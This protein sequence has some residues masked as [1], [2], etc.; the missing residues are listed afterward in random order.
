[1][2][3]NLIWL[4]KK[5]LLSLFILVVLALLVI[6]GYLYSQ[7]W[8]THNFQ[9]LLLG[10]PSY[11]KP[12]AFEL[13]E[14]KV[15]FNIK[16]TCTYG[17][18]IKFAA[19][20]E[21]GRQM[22]KDALGNTYPKGFTMPAVMDIHLLDKDNRTIAARHNFG[23]SRSPAGTYGSKFVNFYTRVGAFL[24][25]GTYT[26]VINIKEIQK[27]LS[28]FDSSIVMSSDSHGN[29]GIRSWHV[30]NGLIN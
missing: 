9:S 15:K 12:F 24:D 27:D 21:Y 13:G 26:V 4:V 6:S 16:R 17:V 8:R 19:M 20:S 28:G 7:G 25:P 29:C 18:G 23:G 2:W 22:V 3:A 10:L 1:M 30:E 5:F 11:S 14:T